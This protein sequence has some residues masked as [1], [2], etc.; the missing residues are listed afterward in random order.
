MF[1]RESGFSNW[2]IYP[3]DP[4]Y[5]FNNAAR[6]ELLQHLYWWHGFLVYD[7]VYKGKRFSERMEWIKAV[8]LIT[9]CDAGTLTEIMDNYSLCTRGLSGVETTVTQTGID[10]RVCAPP[11]MTSLRVFWN[12]KVSQTRIMALLGIKKA[13]MKQLLE[14]IEE[15]DTNPIDFL[16]DTWY[17][18]LTTIN[19]YVF[20]IFAGNLTIININK[21]IRDEAKLQE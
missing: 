16:P 18:C 20:S 9:G 14:K 5:N 21:E 1:K 2:Y 10:T 12:A 17:D 19:S 13:K 11:M 8:A 3:T 4:L 7:K 15:Y 6:K